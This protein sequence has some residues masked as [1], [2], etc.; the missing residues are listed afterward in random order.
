MIHYE[1]C[2]LCSVAAIAWID[3]MCQPD[4]IAYPL[5]TLWKKIFGANRI[6][7]VLFECAKCNSA[8]WIIVILLQLPFLSVLE[9]IL[10]IT[11]TIFSTYIIGLIINRFLK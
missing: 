7:F 6:S 8:W 11:F 1:L 9:L 4:G 5:V 3:V 2:L 10:N